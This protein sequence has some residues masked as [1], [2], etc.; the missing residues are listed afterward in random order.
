M[1]KSE[2]ETY[3]KSQNLARQ[4]IK[5]LNSFI[6]EGVTEIQIK[7]AAEDF[8]IKKGCE[9][10]WYYEIGAF[11]FVGKRTTISIS[12]RNYKPTDE[13]VYENDIVT[14]DLGPEIQGCWGDFARTIIIEN[15]KTVPPEKTNIPEFKAGL[16]AQKQLHEKLKKFITL[17]T[18][19]EDIYLKFNQLIDELG[20]KNLD[21]KKT[22]GHSI[23]KNKDNR[24]Y[25]ESGEKTK[26]KNV[27]LFTFEPHIAKRPSGEYGFKHENI[28]SFKEEKIAAL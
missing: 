1:N 21:F 2:L 10:F 11:V 26:I 12:G 8:M 24:I 4:T 15:G 6:K 16:N 20:Y 3:K 13:K 28:Y 27:N 25:I 9:N 17:E 22:L 18:T 19:F 5:F 23:E 7:E 14:V